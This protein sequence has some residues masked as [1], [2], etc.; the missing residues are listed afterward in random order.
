MLPIS[1]FNLQPGTAQKPGGCFPQLW[2]G[3]INGIRAGYEYSIP[4]WMYRYTTDYFPHPAAQA[5]P[6]HGPTQGFSHGEAETTLRHAIGQ[7]L[8][9]Q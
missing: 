1:F 2:K 4:S 5:V 8:K 7:C 3:G 6:K 9:H